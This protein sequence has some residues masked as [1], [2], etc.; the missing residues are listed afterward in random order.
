MS[1]REEDTLKLD[2]LAA[3]SRPTECV[4]PA[5][6]Y[7]FVETKNLNAFLMRIERSPHRKEVDRCV[8][9]RHALD[10]IQGQGQ[11]GGST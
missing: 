10:C 8:E 5:G 4:S 2:V 7:Q 9:L 3:V 1:D 6:R 11:Y